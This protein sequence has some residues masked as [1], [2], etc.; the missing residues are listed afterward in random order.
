MP[1]DQLPNYLIQKELEVEK[2]N[3]EIKDAE[4]KLLQVLQ[5]YNVTMDDLEEYKR[6]IPL[7]DY[8]KQLK[9]QLEVA[10]QNII[11]LVK[12]LSNEQLE[13]AKWL[14]KWRMLP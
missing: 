8:I 10:K 4:I 14:Q 1:L 2:M 3:G 13:N 6:N 12:K 7:I 9:N 5:H 11:N